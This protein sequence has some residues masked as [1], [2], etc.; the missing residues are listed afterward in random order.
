MKQGSQAR[1]RGGGG[2]F[3]SAH[4]AKSNPPKFPKMASTTDQGMQDK[5]RKL[6]THEEGRARGAEGGGEKLLRAFHSGKLEANLVSLGLC[7]S[8]VGRGRVGL[9][10]PTTYFGHH[11]EWVL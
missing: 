6:E 8:P 10:T 5:L 7:G 4:V 11:D 1:V 9:K 3:L 2:E